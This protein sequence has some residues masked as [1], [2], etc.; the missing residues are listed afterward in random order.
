MTED[1]QRI[2]RY[3][4]GL[5]RR[6][7]LLL[8]ARICANALGLGVLVLIGLQF[9]AWY[10]LDRSSAVAALI[11][12]AGVGAWWVVAWPLLRLWVPAGD[13]ARQAR[14][15]EG[16]EPDL[17][18]RLLTA[19]DRA[20]QPMGAESPALLGLV[21]RRAAAVIERI[22]PAA[23]HPSRQVIARAVLVA[24]ATL[25]ALPVSLLVTGGPVQSWR[26]WT[27]G[28]AARAAV[29]S[30]VATL[31]QE[32]A[33]VGD[34][35][36]R[37]TYP[38]YTGL[39]VKQVPNST[40]DVTGP[41]GTIVQVTARTAEPVEAAGLVAYGQR[42]D[43]V[44][45]DSGRQVD[46]RFTIQNEAGTYHLELFRGGESE[47]SRE[48][49][50]APQ[51]DLA[52]DVTV[53][54]GA[55]RIELPVD[56]DLRLLWVA[57]DDYG[58]ASAQ[59]LVDGRVA[60]R[61]GVPEGRRA[62]VQ[63]LELTSPVALG[64]HAGDTVE[65]VVE[66]W[67]ND[68]WSGSKAGR[69]R[70]VELVV[71]GAGGLERRSAARQK[72]LVRALVPVL[73]PMLTDP[74][75]P[76]DSGRA[77][78][79]WGEEVGRRYEPLLALLGVFL[80][81]GGQTTTEA[82]L[83]RHVVD[84]GQGLIRYT[85]VAF[86]PDS[87]AVPS[88]ESLQ[89]VSEL[90][91]DAVVELESALV[92]LVRMER[93]RALSDLVERTESAGSIAEELESML[94]RDDADAQAL[95][96]RLEQLEQLVMEL[97]QIA[98][99][100]QQGGLQ[101]FVNSRTTEI[102]S[103][104]E[105]IRKAIA[106]GDLEEAAELMSRMARQLEELERGVKE[107]LAQQSSEADESMAAANE[108]IEELEALEEEQRA[109]QEQVQQL[110]EQQDEAFRDEA[111]DLWKQVDAE[112]EQV[113]A[114]GRDWRDGVTEAERAFH[115]VQRAESAVEDSERLLESVTARDLR[116]SWN[117]LRTLEFSWDL[118]YRSAQ[119]AEL[120][121]RAPG[122]VSTRVSRIRGHLERIAELLEELEEVSERTDPATRKRAQEL[123]SRQRELDN[124]LRQAQGQ[125]EEVAR[126]FP[127]EPRGLEES[128][129]DAQGRMQ[130]AGDDLGRGRPM[131]AEGSQGVAAE[132]VREARES[133]EQARDQAAQEASQLGQ[134][135][136]R[137]P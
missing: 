8:G 83:L 64:L 19:V 50:I 60:K 55:E 11:V 103:L 117:S 26:W 115:E 41:P 81:D 130:Q 105:E 89:T 44:V 28:A 10:R 76:G 101:E 120:M 52:P 37:Y 29:E 46:A 69:S 92:T 49:E 97:A 128:L 91:E 9:S 59:L 136:Q 57:R 40:G 119:S 72:E 62:E 4:A 70:A 110:R 7:R 47:S 109:L 73:A 15:V 74:W 116:G 108:L 104:V 14:I 33:R 68:T 16:L 114:R 36:V 79:T 86:E 23:V 75:P 126:E 90:R 1:L 71:L 48:F 24:L 102:G 63:G 78:A 43:S 56:G 84:A 34:L 131:E 132:R 127:V 121:G 58:V 82:R 93:N 61:L 113:V 30:P 35:Q 118:V 5:A 21:A 123:E 65:L 51:Q 124:K 32:H 129:D 137:E 135:G 122:P 3:V 112:A 77:L 67:D 125:A 111:A 106:E 54:A 88:P 38:P 53:D 39:E 31:Q 27:G 6:E 17:R 98:S 133:L 45:D 96:S 80:A 94:A 66:A 87:V 99:Q 95:L 22:P 13:R 18:G 20:G 100:L 107:N 42:L 2:R 134:S 25:I 12:V 85:Q